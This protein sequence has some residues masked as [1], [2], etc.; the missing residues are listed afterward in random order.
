[1][2]SK[3]KKLE[4]KNTLIYK[5]NYKDVTIY[6]AKYD[7]KNSAR[8]LSLYYN[9]SMGKIEEHEEQKYLLV[10]DDIMDGKSYTKLK[11]WH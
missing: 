8:M 4:A 5:K 2:R 11:W 10:D 3:R 1:M 7:H 6:F 9:E